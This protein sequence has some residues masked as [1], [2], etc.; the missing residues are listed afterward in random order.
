MGVKYMSSV[1]ML[2]N[3]KKYLLYNGGSLVFFTAKL[4]HAAHISSV[5]THQWLGKIFYKCDGF[6]QFAHL[7]RADESMQ[8]IGLR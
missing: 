8:L 5:K 3:I 7:S 4:Q 1:F 6:E 2:N